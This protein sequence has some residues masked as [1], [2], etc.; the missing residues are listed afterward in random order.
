MRVEASL[1][2]VSDFACYDTGQFLP[3]TPARRSDGDR[4]GKGER[5]LVLF[6]ISRLVVSI[7]LV[8]GCWL[9]L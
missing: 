9:E 4:G 8:C 1:E 2:T 6:L 5:G 3:P 7:G